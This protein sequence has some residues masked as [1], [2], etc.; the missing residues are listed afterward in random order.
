MSKITVRK[1]RTYGPRSFV[2]NDNSYNV[3]ESWRVYVDREPTDFYIATSRWGKTLIDC[4]ST[5]G[6][7]TMASC[8]HAGISPGGLARLESSRKRIIGSES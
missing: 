3:E 8:W 2:C 6:T 1:T 5:G 7:G 4:S